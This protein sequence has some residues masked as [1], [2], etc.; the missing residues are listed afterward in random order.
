MRDITNIT[1]PRVSLIDERTGLI[2]REWYRFFLNLFRLTGGG[3]SDVTLT[4]LQLTPS[5]SVLMAQYDNAANMI[6]GLYLNPPQVPTVASDNVAPRIEVGTI[7]AQNAENVLISGGTINNTSIGATSQSTGK[8]T[9]IETTGNQGIGT[10]PTT[11]SKSLASGNSTGNV[12]QFNYRAQSV[13]QSDVT[14]LL[15]G[16]SSALSTAAS[17]FTCGTVQ[18]YRADDCTKGAGSTITN[19]VGYRCE[20]LTTGT[21][22]FGYQSNVSSGANKWNF[23]ASGSAP[24]FFSGGVQVGTATLL[25]STVALT[26]GAGAATGTLTNAPAVGN[27]TKWIPIN[28]NGTTRY[29]PAW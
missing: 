23:Y 29:I 26:N 4:D 15:V 13:A 3:T 14:S 10:S 9:T 12:T 6:E 28:D 8:F 19:L 2:S 25:T 20:D 7:A 18:Q 27:P 1:P 16:F 22:N 5:V 11:N 24:N 17:A 21:S